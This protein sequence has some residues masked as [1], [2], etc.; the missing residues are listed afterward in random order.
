MVVLSDAQKRIRKDIDT[1]KF[2][3]D[4]D[5]KGV[6][7]LSGKEVVDEDGLVLL[8]KNQAIVKQV[9]DQAIA[10]PM[11]TLDDEKS[12]ESTTKA[13]NL[14]R[15]M[16]LAGSRWHKF[17]KADALMVTQGLDE[18]KRSLMNHLEPAEEEMERRLQH[19]ENLKEQELAKEQQKVHDRYKLRYAGLVKLG[20]SY[21]GIE[22]KF[23]IGGSS[24]TE[25]IVRL[26]DDTALRDILAKHV[27]TEVQRL[28]DEKAKSELDASAA[29]AALE[30]QL[31]DQAL[32]N[33]QLL[34]QKKVDDENKESKNEAV[35]QARALALEQIGMSR[36]GMVLY[37]GQTTIGYPTLS[38]FTEEQFAQKLIDIKNDVARMVSIASSTVID[39]DSLHLEIP[40]SAIRNTDGEVID[41]PADRTRVMAI[42]ESIA[43]ILPCMEDELFTSSIAKSTMKEMR[44]R[45]QYALDY[46]TGTLRDL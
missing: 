16:R 28:K 5:S 29:K 15:N 6:V 45:L 2:E 30:K 13:K 7:T 40:A 26:A 37:M 39:T 1:L 42:A 43:L 12:I 17:V 9:C 25:D 10:M 20:M 24:I 22:H 4:L 19:L 36:N 27:L 11:P 23:E 44:P 35:R 14:I 21:N 34:D 3:I 8:D 38:E 46:V 32:L 41:Y 31:A 18:Y 33:Q